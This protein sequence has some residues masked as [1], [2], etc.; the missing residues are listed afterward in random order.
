LSTSFT[1]ARRTPLPLAAVVAA[2]LD[3]TTTNPAEVLLK[4]MRP[5][6]RFLPNS[7]LPPRLKMMT[8]YWRRVGLVVVAV[9]VAS[10]S[11]ER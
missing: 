4:G 3:A 1:S 9:V 5:T 8:G 7:R 2:V 11:V 10:R 6:S